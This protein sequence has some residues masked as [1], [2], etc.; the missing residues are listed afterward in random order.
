MATKCMAKEWA[1]Y[2]IRV[3]AIAP[4]L[5]HTRLGDSKLDV[6]PEDREEEL[7]RVK[8][9][10]V[11]M[12]YFSPWSSMKHLEIAKKL[13]IQP[14]TVNKHRKNILEKLKL[15]N[16]ASLISFAKETGLA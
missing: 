4:G 2:N 11:F 7:K 16:I 3:N 6:A 1:E 9:E 13:S 10:V 15:N 12:S 5:V 14:D 8:P